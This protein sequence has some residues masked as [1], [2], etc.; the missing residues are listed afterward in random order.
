LVFA[1]EFGTQTT[2]NAGEGFTTDAAEPTPAKNSVNARVGML[3]TL[4]NDGVDIDGARGT[5]FEVPAYDAY[6]PQTLQALPDP[7]FRLYTLYA[8]LL[9]AEHILEGDPDDTI[10]H[11]ILAGDGFAGSVPNAPFASIG[12]QPPVSGAAD[13]EED[14]LKVLEYNNGG[15]NDPT[16]ETTVL[17]WGS[18]LYIRLGVSGII[19]KEF[20]E[21]EVWV[22]RDGLTWTHQ[23]FLA[24]DF[25]L[26][27]V[28]VGVQGIG[29]VWLD[30]VRTY[31]WTLAEEP[32][33][34]KLV[35]Y[36]PLTGGRRFY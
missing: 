22:S 16:A 5:T 29:R 31:N 26:T 6:R 11:L 8:H 14:N 28:G 17:H 27:R 30:W 18:N 36:P 20:M 4:S 32:V 2:T 34:G 24:G 15:D 12:I 25:A 1:K 3:E 21:G 13:G 35:P 9:L 7:D 10:G 23:N 19:G 33:D